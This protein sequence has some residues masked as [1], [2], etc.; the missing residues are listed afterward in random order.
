[1]DSERLNTVC[2][3]EGTGYDPPRGLCISLELALFFRLISF[4]T[5]SLWPVYECLGLSSAISCLS[6]TICEG[7]LRSERGH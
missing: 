2:T 5:F 4:D 3:R 7:Q 1:M 6:R